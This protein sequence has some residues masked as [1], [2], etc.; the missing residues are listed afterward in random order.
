[1]ATKL[2]TDCLDAQG[3]LSANSVVVSGQKSNSAKLLRMPLLPA[4]MKNVQSKMRSLEWA[5]RFSHCKYMGIFEDP[6]G[7]V[8]P[9]SVVGS[10]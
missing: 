10:G 3:Q 4:R 9:Q 7:Q 5:Q 6:Q 8:T 2:Y 1:M